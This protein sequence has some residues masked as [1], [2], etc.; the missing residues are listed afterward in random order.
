MA[1]IVGLNP[2]YLT[3]VFKKY[4]GLPLM[5]YVNK[6][7]IYNSKKLMSSTSFNISE[8]A[9]KVGF[10]DIHYFSLMFKKMEGL[11]PSQ[12]MQLSKTK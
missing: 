7:R 11:T 12:F 5:K 4:T 6:I 2:I 10:Q 3:T 8:I 1:K 9:F